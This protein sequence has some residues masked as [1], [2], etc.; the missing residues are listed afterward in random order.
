M[1]YN[2]WHLSFFVCVLEIKTLLAI[3]EYKIIS[4]V[5]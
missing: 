1:V 5:S 3:L 2:L 4:I